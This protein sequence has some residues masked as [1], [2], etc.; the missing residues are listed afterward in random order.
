MVEALR[1]TCS[2]ECLRFVGC[3]MCLRTLMQM[4]MHCRID[5][6]LQQGLK[7]ADVAAG[8]GM[9][10]KQ[11]VVLGSGMDTRPWRHAWLQGGR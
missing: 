7:R 3:N 11:V 10:R 9:A 2:R 5:N 1:L 6:E 4:H 8:C